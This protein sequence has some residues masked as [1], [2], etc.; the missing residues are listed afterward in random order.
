MVKPHYPKRPPSPSVKSWLGSDNDSEEEAAIAPLYKKNKQSLFVSENSDRLRLHSSDK[1]AYRDARFVRSRLLGL[2]ITQETLQELHNSRTNSDAAVPFIGRI[3]LQ[4]QK[5]SKENALFQMSGSSLSAMEEAWVGE[6]CGATPHSNQQ[7]LV[8]VTFSSYISQ[9]WEQTRELTYIAV[10]K[11]AFPAIQA[12]R[13]Q[14]IRLSAYPMDRTTVLALLEEYRNISML[15]HLSLCL[16]CCSIIPTYKA[17]VR[18]PRAVNVF[19]KRNSLK[20]LWMVQDV[21]SKPRGYVWDIFKAQHKLKGEHCSTCYLRVREVLQEHLEPT[22]RSH[23]GTAFF[24]NL[25]LTTQDGPLLLA[26]HKKDKASNWCVFWLNED[27]TQSLKMFH[28]LRAMTPKLFYHTNRHA[29][30]APWNISKWNYECLASDFLETDKE[31]VDCLKSLCVKV[32][33]MS[34]IDSSDESAESSLV[35]AF[36]NTRLDSD[37][38]ESD[39]RPSQVV[40]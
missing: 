35:A 14:P 40:L 29:P 9:T 21:S 34:D 30:F 2:F 39:T 37:T 6:V 4:L 22:R 7:F 31:A 11:N 5:H 18:D 33:H 19:G 16:Q 12:C 32:K 8:S 17:P 3:A 20:P 1:Y 23:N 25:D 27:R 15:G 10:A 36:S 24:P 28:D 38:I 26:I 13:A